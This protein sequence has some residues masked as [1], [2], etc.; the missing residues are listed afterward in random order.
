MKKLARSQGVSNGAASTPAPYRCLAPIPEN[1]PRVL[2]RARQFVLWRAVWDA[3]R[4][5]WTKRP[6][7]VSG[8]PASHSN[9]DTWNTFEAVVAA[10]RDYAWNGI[11][12]VLTAEDHIVG[13]DIDHAVDLKRRVIKPFAVELTRRI[14]SYTEA[15]PSG[16]GLR[17]FAFGRLPDTGHKVDGLGDDGSGAL[18]IYDRLR[19]LTITGRRLPGAPATIRSRQRVIDQL[20]REFFPAPVIAPASAIMA[21]ALNL[22]D[23]TVL[24]VACASKGGDAFRRLYFDGDLTGYHDDHSRADLALVGILAF[25]SGGDVAQIERLFGASALVRDKWLKRQDYR[26]RTIAQALSG[27]TEFYDP[28]YRTRGLWSLS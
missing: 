10:Y 24:D 9:S 22:A 20:L 18:E 4:G 8:Y 7:Q 3:E 15:S 6:Y 11:G 12:F 27:M 28:N 17:G 13:F 19:F 16:A 1:I 5:K 2:T 26:S 23:Q 14:A 25:Y 21:P